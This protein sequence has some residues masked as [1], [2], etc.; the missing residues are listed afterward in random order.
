ME[1]MIITN[2]SIKIEDSALYSKDGILN[3][4]GWLRK[5][6]PANAVLEHRSDL[7]LSHEWVVHN[8]L[9]RL[10]LWKSHTKDVNMN[11][12]ICSVTEIIYILVGALVW[13]FIR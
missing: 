5:A 13:P 2:N 4:L 8:A 9:Y 6:Y 11:W 1:D 10:G 3:T 12:P 7:S